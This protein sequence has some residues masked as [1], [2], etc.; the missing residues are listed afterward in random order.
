M[1]DPTRSDGRN[2]RSPGRSFCRILAAR[3]SWVLAGRGSLGRNGRSR[4]RRWIA[5]EIRCECWCMEAFRTSIAPMFGIGWVEEASWRRVL[6]TRI[7]SCISRNWIRE[8]EVRSIRFACLLLYM[9]ELSPRIRSS[10]NASWERRKRARLVRKKRPTWLRF[11]GFC[12]RVRWCAKTSRTAKEWICWLPFCWSWFS[13][14]KRRSGRL[15]AFSSIRFRSIISTKRWAERGLMQFSFY[16]CM[17]CRNCSLSSHARSFRSWFL[18]WSRSMSTFCRFRSRG[19]CIGSF[20]RCQWWRWCGSG[21]WFS[22]RETKRWCVWRW[23]WLRSIRKIWWVWR[24]I[25]I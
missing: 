24:T 19:S 18:A 3:R 12:W 4:S 8:F 20:T 14:K 16:S 9:S 6:R 1:L 22:S 11:G 25:A 17:N 2:T 10:R 5:S 23:R 7:S 21:T 13:T 15:S